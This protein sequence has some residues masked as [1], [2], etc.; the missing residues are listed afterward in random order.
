MPSIDVAGSMASMTDPQS[1]VPARLVRAWKKR[2]QAGPGIP[3]EGAFAV[4]FAVPCVALF[5]VEV[6]APHE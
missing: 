4:P 6:P 1:A 2:K 3:G 5:S